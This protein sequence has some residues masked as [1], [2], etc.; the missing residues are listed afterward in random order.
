M[1]DLRRLPN[2]A[3]LRAFEAAARHGNFSRAAEEI[4]VT[5]GAIS[6]QVR[7]LEDDLGIALFTRHGKRIAITPEGAQFAHVVRKALD[8]IGEAAQA[9]RMGA[10]QQRLT[11]TTLPSLASRWLAP[12]LGRFIDRHP[13]LEVML[14]SSIALTDFLRESVDVG[15]RFGQGKY[16]GLVAEKLMDD[17]FYPVASPYFNGGKLPRTSRQLKNLPLLRCENEPWMPWFRAAGVDL[18]EPSG[19]IVFQDS[20]LLVRAAVEGEGIALARHVLAMGEIDAGDL[21]RLF[22]VVIPCPQSYYLVC[23]PEALRK[24]QVQSFREWVLAEAAQV[25]TADVAAFRP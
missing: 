22:D 13:D 1:A 11:I 16:P 3:A 15:L 24:P 17:Y 18:P 23:P 10:R 8:E 20:S 19:G 9:L 6:H 14:Q 7:A 4:H 5:H 21:V 2:L 12:R 25:R